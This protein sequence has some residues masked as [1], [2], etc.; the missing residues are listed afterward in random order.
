MVVFAESGCPMTFFSQDDDLGDLATSL[1][2]EPINT[3]T[4]VHTVKLACIPASDFIHLDSRLPSPTRSSNG[5]ISPAI[6]QSYRPDGRHH[7]AYIAHRTRTRTY[8]NAQHTAAHATI[9]VRSR[10]RTS[11]RST[12]FLSGKAS[13]SK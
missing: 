3:I 4:E 6:Y 13:E 11:P 9:D 2:E 5:Q 8:E 10:H 12:R 1:R 7:P